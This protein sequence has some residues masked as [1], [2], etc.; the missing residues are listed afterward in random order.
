MHYEDRVCMGIPIMYEDGCQ[1]IWV[2]TKYIKMVVPKVVIPVLLRQKLGT[3]SG[4]W[5]LNYEE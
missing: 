2:Y 1:P 3:D 5:F 4:S